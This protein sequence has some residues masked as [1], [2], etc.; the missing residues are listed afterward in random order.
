MNPKALRK[1]PLRIAAAV[2]LC[3][4]LFPALL[5]PRLSAATIDLTNAVI[6]KPASPKKVVEYAALELQTHLQLLN[7]GVAVPIATSAGAGK[8]PFYVGTRPTADTNATYAAEEARWLIAADAV[9]LYGNDNDVS[10]T[11]DIVTDALDSSARP[12]SLF[13]VYEFLENYCGIKWVESGANGITYTAQSTLTPANGSGSWAPQLNQRKIRLAYSD[14]F[15]TDT[16]LAD[17]AVPDEIKFTD[18]EFDARAL[19]ERVWMR[20]MRMGSNIHISYGHAFTEWWE[21]YG[22]D[23][24]VFK[25]ANL[26]AM[27][28]NGKRQPASASRPE[29]IKLCVSN[30]DTAKQVARYHFFRDGDTPRSINSVGYN[31]NAIEN[32]SRDFC[33]CDNCKALDVL[34]PGEEDLAVDDRVLTDRYVYFANAVL[35]EA[36]QMLLDNYPGQDA[37]KVQ[38]LFYAYS[39]YNFPPR[40]QKL[41]DG[42]FLFLIPNLGTPLTE[43]D[44]Y[45]LDWKNKDADEFFHRPN[46]LNQDTGF[47][48]GFEYHMFEKYRLGNVRLA[49]KGTDY[50]M[51]WAFWPTSGITYYIMARAMYRPEKTFSDWET[52]YFATFG[53]AAADIREYY[54]HWRQVWNERIM[55]NR[56][57]IEAMSAGKL[58]LLRAKVTHL[59]DQLYSENDYDRTDAMLAL[60]AT[61]AGLTAQQSARIANLRLANQHNRLKYHAV[62]DNCLGSPTTDDTQ[63]KASSRA[64]LDFRI[65]NKSALNIHWEALAYLENV[66]EDNA[67]IKRLL[68]TEETSRKTWREQCDAQAVVA[69]QSTSFS[70]RP[71]VTGITPADVVAGDTVT[72]K[73]SDLYDITDL[74]FGGITATEWT[75]VDAS[76][77]TA[78]IPDGV[79]PSGNITIVTRGDSAVS[80]VKYHVIN[81][82]TTIRRLSDQTVVTGHDLTLTASSD[83]HPMPTYTWEVSADSGATW[84]PIADGGKYSGNGTEVLRITGVDESMAGL[85]Y[86]YT[87]TNSVTA[88]AMTSNAATLAVQPNTR[89][90]HPAGIAINSAG[91]IYVADNGLR[92]VQRIATGNTLSAF[93]GSAG[94]S[95]T[96]DGSG[97]AAR[98]TNPV[99]LSIAPGGQVVIADTGAANLRLANSTGAVSTLASNLTSAAIA[100]D[101]SG[102]TYVAD[103]ATNCIRMVTLSGVSTIIAG[104]PSGQSGSLDAT[105]TAATFNAPA[106]IAIAA[107]GTIY[108]A[109]TGNHTI[110]AISPGT[111]AVTTIAGVATDDGYAD[112]D[113]LL[114]AAFNSPRALALNGSTLYIADTDNSLIRALNL[115][116]G[117]VTTLAGRPGAQPTHGYQAA[118]GTAAVFDHPLGFALD[119]SGNLY[120]ADTGNAVIRKITVATSDVTTL[121]P[122]V[123][124]TGAN[125]NGDS[126]GGGGGGSLSLIHAGALVLLMLLRFIQRR[127]K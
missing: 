8:F 90:P 117:V 125:G 40:R 93:A 85:K 41:A 56:E 31:V 115:I 69:R 37:S 118:T 47:P 35:A 78:V 27:L 124:N 18:A 12:G 20:R 103:S 45:F 6:V 32:D 53:S 121:T 28:P 52:E 11:G 36:R 1:T 120:V 77:V 98:F 24:T 81:P 3:A 80:S 101:S 82:V 61:R 21:K 99:A 67:G 59:T 112:G 92:T 87:A 5:S 73:G 74:K 68:G 72:I 23:G 44:Q 107:S 62:R 76:T 100:T 22:A 123:T 34:L 79:P 96:A 14:K 104:S 95:G 9:W 13:A 19:D 114:D 43:I 119:N 110:R 122:A 91:T 42:V 70:A 105:G 50:D 2:L 75:R 17:G 108:V 57:K 29:R 25:N 116:A 51:C 49:L 111:R 15:R 7:G 66:Y 71:T 55:N 102:N 26:F 113:A 60:A 46:D 54:T 89:Y 63:K 30:P 39:R 83:G 58:D 38:V 48:I 109:D 126:G 106:G 64:L 97:E 86:R 94:Q 88:V 84:T 33:N 4:Q 10:G 65:A 16:I 127:E